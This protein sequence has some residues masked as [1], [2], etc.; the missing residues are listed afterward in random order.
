MRIHLH[1]DRGII[2]F[3]PQDMVTPFI[4]VEEGRGRRDWLSERPFER[5]TN[6]G[7]GRGFFHGNGR[8]AAREALSDN[9]QK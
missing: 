7:S 8:G 3:I 2:D 5:E 9:L 6:G 1:G 4:E